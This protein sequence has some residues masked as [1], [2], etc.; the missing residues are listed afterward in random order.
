MHKQE[1][2][3]SKGIGIKEVKSEVQ[4]DL[5]KR[6]GTK[7]VHAGEKI[8]PL[9]RGVVTNIDFSTTFAYDTAEE[10]ANVFYHGE[11]GF[12]YSRHG[13]PTR[14]VFEKKIAL[15]ENGE[16][17]IGFSS[18]MAAISS[19]ICTFTNPGDEIIVTDRC[20]PGTRHLF[21]QYLKKWGFIIHF[22][23]ATKVENVAEKLSSKTKMIYMECPANP[24]LSLCDI[25]EIGKLSREVGAKYVFDNTFASPIN[26]QPLKLGVDIVVHSATK[27]LSGHSDVLC[28]GIVASVKDRADIMNTAVYFGGVMPPFDAWLSIRGMKTLE[29]RVKRHNEN[30]QAIAEFLEDHPK[31]REVYYPGL[32]SHPQHNLAKKQMFGYGGMVSFC[33]GKSDAD[34]GKFLNSLK[35]IKRASSLGSVESLA[36]ASG[37]M[38][39]LEFTEEEKRSIGI[40]PGFIR[41]STGIEDKDDLIEDID[42]A[43][44]KL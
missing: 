34:G 37:S 32:P 42:Q 36:Q 5:G 16:A 12:A 35:I 4:A 13:N 31:V 3:S 7:V 43:L 19:T 27:Y 18:G 26:Q 39:Y 11:S 2:D 40:N 38:I 23:N 8:N 20:Y 1:K 29:L 24:T 25:E 28:G 22:V 14:S 21:N 6:I 44:S 30:G 15:L 9:T 10:W 41:Y 17:G 33:V